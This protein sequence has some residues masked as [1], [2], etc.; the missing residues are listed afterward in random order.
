MATTGLVVEGQVG[1]GTSAGLTIGL[2]VVAALGLCPKYMPLAFLTSFRENMLTR[3]NMRL[4][5]RN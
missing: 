1:V 4:I 5:N 2:V 3:I